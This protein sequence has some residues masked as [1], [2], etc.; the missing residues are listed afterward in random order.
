MSISPLI[1]VFNAAGKLKGLPSLPAIPLRIPLPDRVLEI[2]ILGGF[3]G[4]CRSVVQDLT[5]V[6]RLGSFHEKMTVEVR[7]KDGRSETYLAKTEQR[8]WLGRGSYWKKP[9]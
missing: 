8:R 3:K 6:S 5:A 9:M 1:A 2:G 4:L 7:F